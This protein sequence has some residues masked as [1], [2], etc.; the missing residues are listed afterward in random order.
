MF[1]GKNEKTVP[2][3]FDALQFE[4]RNATDT[5]IFSIYLQF[6]LTCITKGHLL[7]QCY[8]FSLLYV[9]PDD[10]WNIN[11]L[12]GDERDSLYEEIYNLREE[13]DE[14]IYQVK[15]LKET[16]KTSNLSSYVIENNDQK[17][18]MMTGLTWGIFLQIFFFL[19]SFLTAKATNKH[20][21]PLREQFFITLIKLRHGLTFDLLATAKGIKKSTAIDYFW[22]WINLM[23]AKLNFLIKF[24]DR[25]NIFR[26]IPPVFKTNFPKLTAIVDCFEIFID[27]PKN[28]KAR[29]QCWSN[30]KNHCTVKFFISCSPLGHINFISKAYGGR[31]SDVQIVRESGY[32][33]NQYHYPG[34]EILAD[35]GFTLR[36]EF[37]TYCGVLFYTPSFTKGKRQLSAEEVE[38]SRKLSSIRIHI[39]RVIGLLKNRFAIL[40][41]SLPIQT[42]QSITNEVENDELASIDKIVQVCCS[43][44][45][46]GESI[47]YKEK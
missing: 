12:G 19:S 10:Q 24:Q 18:K 30:Y 44:V 16:L 5:G 13:R 22:K 25:S 11:L 33:S 34:D 40:K 31:A 20:S 28:F 17:A 38:T 21:L 42:V 36:E 3:D 35:R 41:R 45:N 23:H 7:T 2:G 9:G 29:A 39:E 1:F 27:S 8:N 32:I 14:A 37:A 46:L 43:L 26:I 15:K 6:T 4:L 47:V